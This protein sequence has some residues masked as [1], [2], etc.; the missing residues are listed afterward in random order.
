[1]TRET[2]PNR[3]APNVQ[4]EI[5]LRAGTL[6]A[7]E[8]NDGSLYTVGSVMFHGVVDDREL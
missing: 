8:I 2:R 4:A 3:Q 1:V 6:S 5:I 7:V